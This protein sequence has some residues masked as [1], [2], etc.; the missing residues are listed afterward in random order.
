MMRYG[1]I[2]IADPIAHETP[3]RTAGRRPRPAGFERFN[4]VA[5]HLFDP[6][7][8]INSDVS[9]DLIENLAT[10]AS[11]M[12]DLIHRGPLGI[13]HLADLMTLPFHF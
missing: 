1:T 3:T 9:D 10:Q 7:R 13:R 2:G 8:G 11:S 6:P 4:S 5:H 12:E